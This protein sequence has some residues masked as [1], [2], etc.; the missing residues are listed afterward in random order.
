MVHDVD[1]TFYL[2]GDDGCEY[3]AKVTSSVR[4]HKAMVHDIDVTYYV[5]VVEGCDYK[6]KVA[7]NV[8]THKAYP[9]YCLRNCIDINCQSALELNGTIGISGNELLEGLVGELDGQ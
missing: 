3:K 7:G 9:W 8:R 4:T 5:C 1:V 6:A 2:C